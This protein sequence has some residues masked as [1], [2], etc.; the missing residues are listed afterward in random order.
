MKRTFAPVRIQQNP[1]ALTVRAGIK[2]LY[3][4]L[5]WIFAF[6]LVIP[7]EIAHAFISVALGYKVHGGGIAYESVGS[8]YNI[9]VPQIRAFFISHE[10]ADTEIEGLV[11]SLAPF[12][13][14]FPGLALLMTNDVSYVGAFFILVGMTGFS[15][16]AAILQDDRIAPNAT[17]LFLFGSP[18]QWQETLDNYQ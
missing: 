17:R 11:I 5:G 9:S 15:D 13:F 2:A 12:G 4:Y 18:K 3:S 6:V 14:I 16:V 10:P 7:H 1:D 8:I